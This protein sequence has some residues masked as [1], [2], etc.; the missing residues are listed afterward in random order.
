MMSRYGV[1]SSSFQ[2]DQLPS[3]TM[4]DTFTNTFG[5]A[6]RSYV[7]TNRSD[8]AN[9]L[10]PLSDN[11]VLNEGFRDVVDDKRL[12]RELRYEFLGHLQVLRVDEDIVGQVILLQKANTTKEVLAQQK[13]IVRFI[14]DLSFEKEDIDLRY[15]ELPQASLVSSTAQAIWNTWNKVTYFF[16]NIISA[17]I[18]PS[19]NTTDHFR[20]LLSKPQQKVCLLFGLASLNGY[21]SIH[22]VSF[23]MVLQF[24]RQEVPP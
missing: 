11:V 7:S 14:L 18:H 2:S 4:P 10:L 19:H 23:E 3:V 5:K 24:W 8:Y 22:S 21:R 1:K 13:L 20:I 12:V 15:G 16:L 9:A 17:E 6:A